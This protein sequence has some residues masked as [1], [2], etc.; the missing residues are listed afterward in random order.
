MKQID[1]M[2][3]VIDAS[4]IRP[5]F[6][7]FLGL[8][9]GG[10]VFLLLFLG[11]LSHFISDLNVVLLGGLCVGVTILVSF[12]VI[13]SCPQPFD[14]RTLRAPGIFVY[15]Y[16]LI[17][18]L[19]LPFVAVNFPGKAQPV[20]I[21]ATC[22]GFLSTL[23]GI[24]FVQLLAPISRRQT[25]AWMSKEA[26]NP[27][28]MMWLSIALL[29]V[30]LAIFALY[31]HQIG[32]LPILQAIRGNS[33]TMDLVNAR[34]SALKLIPGRIRYVYSTLRNMLFPYVTL[35]LFVNAL[36]RR[37]WTT[38]VVFIV[39]FCCNMLLAV[40]TLEKSLAGANL[41]MLA[42]AW[43]ITRGKKLSIRYILLLGIF[44]FVFPVFA[45]YAIYQFNIDLSR[46][47]NAIVNRIFVLPAEVLY[48]YYAFFPDRHEFLLGRTLPYVSKLFPGGAFPITN[49]IYLFMYPSSEVGSGGANVAYIGGLWA[50]FSWFGVIAGGFIAG[51]VIQGLQ[52]LIVRLPKSAPSVVLQAT[53][54][55]WVVM[56]TSIS[57]PDFLESS[58]VLYATVLTLSLILFL[59]TTHVGR[60]KNR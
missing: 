49:T 33:N 25:L 40:A 11:V 34:E 16:M 9:M 55:Y 56:L 58:G 57:L 13:F 37:N 4:A 26:F 10:I 41:I 21:F 53:L 39:A 24:V 1:S 52:V 29:V 12:S 3:P 44:A 14:I 35:L 59:P 32:D 20:F 23:G 6:S 30:C 45:L 51:A 8:L 42:F 31:V 19:P 43:L 5:K 28:I 48:H 22:L 47:L 18:L 38:R 2:V 46:V 54:A 36:I 7:K 27:P 60:Q 15:S 50:D 17:I